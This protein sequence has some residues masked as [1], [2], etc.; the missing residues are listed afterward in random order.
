MKRTRKHGEC[1]LFAKIGKNGRLY[2]NGHQEGVGH[3]HAYN[4]G[5]YLQESDDGRE[6]L[7]LP[8]GKGKSGVRLPI[9]DVVVRHREN[10]II[11]IPK[12]R[13]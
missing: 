13:N 8:V 1:S 2:L 7:I 3:V 9:L 6:F 10:K 12:E 4:R 5:M 11:R